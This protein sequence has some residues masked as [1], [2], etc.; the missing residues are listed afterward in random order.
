M[1]ITGNREGERCTPPP[2]YKFCALPPCPCIC[3]IAPCSVEFPP[4]ASCYVSPACPHCDEP[5]LSPPAAAPPP[6]IDALPQPLDARV[7]RKRVQPRY[8]AAARFSGYALDFEVRAVERELRGALLRDGLKPAL[9]YRLARYNDPLTPIFLRRNE[10]LI[11]LE[12]F[13]WP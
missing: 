8:A 3:A 4:T 6:D 10:V 7:Q 2:G 13:E 12:D 11:D 5:L 9:G 1:C